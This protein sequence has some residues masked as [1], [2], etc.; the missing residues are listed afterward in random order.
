VRLRQHAFGFNQPSRDL[1]LSPD[2]AIFLG[3]VLIPVK[4]LI[5]GEAICQVPRDRVTYYH[6][7]LDQHDVLSAEGLAAESLLPQADRSA[8]ENG[9]G[10]MQIHPEF[11]HLHWDVMGCAPIVVT[12]PAVAAAQAALAASRLR[13]AA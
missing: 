1:Y 7:E 12:G 9:G 5:D 13:A 4:Y 10:V 11:A 3:K 8:F 2:H 6:V